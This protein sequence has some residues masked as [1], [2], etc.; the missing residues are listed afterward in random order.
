MNED[1]TPKPEPTLFSMLTRDI[2]M[3]A[4]LLTLWAAADTW[5]Q[6]SQLPLAEWLG[7]INA[8]YAGYVLGA[9]A[10][11]WGHY[12]G[13][14]LTGAAAPR[15]TVA[16]FS[17]FRFNFDLVGNSLKQ[18]HWMS[19][20][21]WVAHWAL[22]LAVIAL[23]PMDSLPRVALAS[24]IFGFIVYA[25]LLETGILRQTFNGTAPAEALKIITPD[26][27]RK[28]GVVASLVGLLTLSVMG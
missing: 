27:L 15:I 3:M 19:F 28:A 10:H 23:I 6:V 8:I 11:E 12:A 22:L 14:K 5:H 20:G 2:G 16:G 7:V 24:S 21:G 17:L 4:M 13:A 1:N 18:F 9:V 26:N 25:T